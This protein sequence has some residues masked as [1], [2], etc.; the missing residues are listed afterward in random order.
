MTISI[1]KAATED[2]RLLCAIGMTT[3]SETFA[4][5]N[6]EEDM[7]LYLENTFSSEAIKKEIEDVQ[8][9]FL[10]AYDGEKAVGY[11]KVKTTAENPEGLQAVH[12]MEI[13]RFYV[14]KEYIGK[15]VGKTLMTACLQYGRENGHDLV[16][17]GVWELNPRAISFY[18][19][20]GFE[21]FG[22]H[23]FMLGNDLQTDWL[24]KKKLT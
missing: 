20:W 18:K 7:R 5:H 13:E 24:F 19:K 2:V 15:H 12:A 6:T 16:W 21:K 22:Q 8:V 14:T 1:R 10:L 11:A 9:C 3:F 4:E 23:I 17:L